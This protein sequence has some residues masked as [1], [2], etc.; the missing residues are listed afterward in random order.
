MFDCVG[1]VHV[2]WRSREEKMAPA[3]TEVVRDLLRFSN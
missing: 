1:E 3:E 2:G